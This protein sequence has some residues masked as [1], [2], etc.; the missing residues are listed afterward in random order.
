MIDLFDWVCSMCVMGKS[1]AHL[2]RSAACVLCVSQFA[3]FDYVCYLCAIGKSVAHLIRFAA[4]V[5]CV[6]QFAHFDQVC[7]L[8]VIRS[9]LFI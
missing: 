6:S 9:R 7:R 5:L 1:V 8:S 4:C 2:I 3:H